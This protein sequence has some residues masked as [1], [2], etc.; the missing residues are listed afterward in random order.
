[1]DPG[2]DTLIQDDGAVA[3]LDVAMAGERGDNPSIKRFAIEKRLPIGRKEAVGREKKD[4]P[5]AKAHA[6]GAW[7]GSDGVEG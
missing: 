1:V 4:H 5:P 3:H 6:G 2:E 7:G